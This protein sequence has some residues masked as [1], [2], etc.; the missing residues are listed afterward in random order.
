[1][2][3]IV[4]ALTTGCATSNEIDQAFRIKELE[5]IVVGL[6][7]DNGYLMA[8]LVKQEMHIRSLEGGMVIQAQMMAR[9]RDGCD[10]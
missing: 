9:A 3:T 1:M 10:L 2:T 8:A 4:V 5:A 7:D 6:Q